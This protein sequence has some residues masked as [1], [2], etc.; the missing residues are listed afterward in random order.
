MTAPVERLE[1]LLARVVARRDEPAT[2]LRIPRPTAPAAAMRPE[3]EELAAEAAIDAPHGARPGS[4]EPEVAE[5]EVSEAELAEAERTEAELAEAELTEAERAEAELTEAERVEVVA[6]V[7]AYSAGVADQA[8]ADLGDVAALG[9]AAEE[10]EADLRRPEAT[11]DVEIDLDDDAGPTVIRDVAS[12][13]AAATGEQV[14]SAASSAPPV[15][16]DEEAGS[17]EPSTQRLPSREA[18]RAGATE[19]RPPSS[20]VEPQREDEPD[21][22]ALDE[23]TRKR[24]VVADVPSPERVSAVTAASA[25]GEGG[26]AVFVPPAPEAALRGDDVASA[27]TAAGSSLPGPVVVAIPS[28]DGRAVA[29]FL[30]ELETPRSASSF[31]A[32]MDASLEL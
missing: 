11:D 9:G 8:G 30:T 28:R 1:H 3:T 10:E 20:A 23:T 14:L 12:A 31:G 15:D 18:A 19:V 2:R 22:P 24:P 5:I 21:A 27:P 26:P 7:E 13:V 6:P 4:E 29:D 25:A 16:E 17:G 32:V